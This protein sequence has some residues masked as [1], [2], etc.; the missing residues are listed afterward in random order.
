MKSFQK[1]PKAATVWIGV[2]DMWHAYYKRHWQLLCVA[3]KP[4]AFS[5]ERFQ[6]GGDGRGGTQTSAYVEH[7]W[8]GPCCR[9]RYQMS[10]PKAKL[11]A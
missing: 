7:R 5:Q 10:L 2:A 8:G 1:S 4:Q 9:G 11:G 6:N 3:C